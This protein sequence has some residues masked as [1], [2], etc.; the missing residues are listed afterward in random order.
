MSG[1]PPDDSPDDDLP[2]DGPDEINT[3][4]SIFEQWGIP[5]DR[6]A[7][8]TPRAAQLAMIPGR[9]SLVI[10]PGYLGD[11][12]FDAATRAALE[13][14]ARG[15]GVVIVQKPLV[16]TSGAELLGFLGLT[17]SERSVRVTDVRFTDASALT[18]SLDSP[19][20]R[21]LRITDN[22]ATQPSEVFVFEPAA[23]TT[24]LARALAV[25]TEPSEDRIELV[26]VGLLHGDPR[27]SRASSGS[28][29][30]RSRRRRLAAPRRD[31]T[32]L[33]G[34]LTASAISSSE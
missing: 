10:V 21:T 33:S 27:R 20:E 17:R 2:D 19:E 9:Y 18:N 30:S 24:A 22:P 6:P 4:A 28:S 16:T 26:V 12:E 29:S 15:G 8:R 34:T 11:Y 25:V 7:L 14:F 5:Y 3:V 13:A 1:E 31:R 23:G 32:V